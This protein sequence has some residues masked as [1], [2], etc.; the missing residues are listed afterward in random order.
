MP[1][2]TYQQ[3]LANINAYVE[4]TNYHWD[5][6]L[7]E[8]YNDDEFWEHIFEMTNDDWWD[9]VDIEPALRIQYPDYFRR[10]P[11]VD[12]GTAYIK[13]CLMKG[14]KLYKKDVKNANFQTFRAWMNIKDIINEINGTPS[15]QYTDKERQTAKELVNPTP[16]EKLF[17]IE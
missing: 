3:K 5:R 1:K 13:E 2:R 8:L 14:K 11:K 9:W 4:I 10:F 7:G 12:S 16:F 17:S 6:L 15:K